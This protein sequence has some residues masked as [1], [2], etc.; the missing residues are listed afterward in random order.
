MRG[1]SWAEPW[2]W[3]RVS[4]LPTA[5]QRAAGSSGSPPISSTDTLTDRHPYSTW[6][7]SPRRRRLAAILSNNGRSAGRH[8]RADPSEPGRRAPEPGRAPVGLPNLLRMMSALRILDAA[9]LIM[10]RGC[11]ARRHRRS[12]SRR[13]FRGGGRCGTAA[14]SLRLAP[15]LTSRFGFLPKP[16]FFVTN[17]KFRRPKAGRAAL[18]V[19]VPVRWARRWARAARVHGVPRHVS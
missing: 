1:R 14:P 7:T 4:T 8:A 17:R 6:N 19:R 3:S 9:L 18:R 13:A 11:R 12:P 16:F 2:C 5:G 15:R 10:R